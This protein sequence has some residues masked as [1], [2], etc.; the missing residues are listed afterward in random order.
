MTWRY[1]VFYSTKTAVQAI[2]ALIIIC[3]TVLSAWGPA[4]AEDQQKKLDVLHLWATDEEQAALEQYRKP[5]IDRGVRWVHQYVN[6]N[7]DGLQRAFAERSTIDAAPSVVFWIGDEALRTQ[8]ATGRMRLIPDEVGDTRFS[9]ILKPEVYEVLRF[10]N[11]ITSVPL[12]IHVQA[13]GHYNVK[14]LK[15]VG[16]EIPKNWAEFIETAKLV[17]AKGVAPLSMSTEP[18]QMRSLLQSFLQEYLDPEEFAAFFEKGS[19]VRKLRAK[20]LQMVTL[21]MLLRDE[22]TNED[23]ANLN[24]RNSVGKV[25]A[26]KAMAVFLGDYASPLFHGNPDTICAPPPGNEYLIWAFD[27]AAFTTRKSE[28]ERQAQNIFIDVIANPVNHTNFVVKK[29]GISP[30]N[31]VPMAKADNC[32]RFVNQWWSTAAHKFHLGG[33]IWSQHLNIISNRLKRLFEGNEQDAEAAVDDVITS[34]L[35]LSQ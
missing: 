2:M 19:D 17:K 3:L 20:L 35:E 23:R 29:G 24:W 9:K 22:Y 28:Q 30:Y 13:V 10:R 32:T 34:I 18:W 33:G 7:F 26:G 1:A 12:G 25:D 11:G 5:A 4:W 8:I 14:V 6:T 21:I 15:S 16:R 27:T 31:D